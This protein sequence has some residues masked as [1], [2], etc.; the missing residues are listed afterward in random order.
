VACPSGGRDGLAVRVEQVD[1]DLLD[2]GSGLVR[3]RGEKVLDRA[4]VA[5]LDEVQQPGMIG[6]RDDRVVDLPTPLR[7]LVDAQPC[8]RVGETILEQPR[9][10][11]ARRLVDAIEGHALLVGDLDVR[12]FARPGREVAVQAQGM[13]GARW[14]L[15]MRRSESPA[16]A[17]A[18]EAALTPH[19]PGLLAGTQRNVFDDH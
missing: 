13:G 8:G 5:G 17:S 15:V 4:L 14:D 12:G 2:S 6:V 16:A 10:L 19:E 9:G 3:Q 18:G 1:A 11:E 7:G